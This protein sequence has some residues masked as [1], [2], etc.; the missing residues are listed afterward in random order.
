M[1]Y[2][3]YFLKLP[4]TYYRYIKVVNAY[5]DYRLKPSKS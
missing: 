5:N 2:V 1:K 3:C 4:N